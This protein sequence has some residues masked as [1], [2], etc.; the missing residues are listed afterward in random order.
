MTAREDIAFWSCIV[1]S[2][3]WMAA[4]NFGIGAVWLALALVFKVFDFCY[5]K[6]T[7]GCRVV[8]DGTDNDEAS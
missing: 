6:H 7:M 1:L 8:P 2:N 3:V 4:E 5:R